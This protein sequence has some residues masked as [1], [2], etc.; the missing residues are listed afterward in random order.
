MQH[1]LPDTIESIT[2][3]L[4]KFGSDGTCYRVGL[5]HLD[6][7]NIGQCDHL[8]AANAGQLNTN[9]QVQLGSEI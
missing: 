3:Q 5:E 4:P 2:F 7:Q 8:K 6:I 1:Q 9:T